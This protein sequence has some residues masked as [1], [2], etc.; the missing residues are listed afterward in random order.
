[1]VKVSTIFWNALNLTNL[2]WQRRRH[3]TFSYLPLLLY[4]QFIT[5][6][7]VDGKAQSPITSSEVRSIFSWR[8]KQASPRVLWRR[9]STWITSSLEFFRDTPRWKNKKEGIAWIPSSVILPLYWQMATKSRDTR[10]AARARLCSHLDCET[11]EEKGQNCLFYH[12]PQPNQLI[13]VSEAGNLPQVSLQS[14]T[15][16]TWVQDCLQIK[17]QTEGSEWKNNILPSWKDLEEFLK[18]KLNPN[19]NL[20]FYCRNDCCSQLN[21]SPLPAGQKARGAWGCQM[22]FRP[23]RQETPRGNTS[24]SCRSKRMGRGSKTNNNSQSSSS[25]RCQTNAFWRGMGWHLW[26]KGIFF[27]FSILH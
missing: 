19:I 26:K 3:C 16:L 23:G 8:L 5:V 11:V 25:S 10:D 17:D 13:M 6:V 4:I 18:R 20:C 21:A 15:I 1:M 2:R 27:F 7:F 22:E 24:S 9:E 12:F 14:L